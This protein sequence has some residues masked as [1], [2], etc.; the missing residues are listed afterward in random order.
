MMKLGLPWKVNEND[1]ASIH[2][3]AGILVQEIYKFIRQNIHGFEN[4]EI[5]WIAKEVGIRTGVR[6]KGKSTLTNDDVLQCRKYD[7]GICNGAW[8]IEHWKTGNKR[9]DMTYFRENDFYSIPS[10]CLQSDRYENLFFAGK[11]I[12]AEEKAIASAR[13][14]GTCMGTGYASGI[15]AS[16]FAENKSLQEAIRQIQTDMQLV[17]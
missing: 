16:Y 14:I 4:T 15:L 13:V 1:R 10:G 17:R 12:S 9:V 8:A 11:I 3:K 7:D 5:E 6:A 2:E